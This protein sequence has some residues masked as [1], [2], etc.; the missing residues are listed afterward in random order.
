MGWGIGVGIGWPNASAGISYVKQ[1]I[2]TF[3]E[4]VLSYPN[5]VFEAEACLTASLTELNTIGLLDKAS[6]VITPNAYNTAILYDVVPN[7][8]LGDMDVIRATTATRVNANGLI[9]TV[10]LNIP[11]LDYSKGTCPSVLI[12]PQE[13][14][15]LNYSEEFDNPFWFKGAVGGVANPIVTPNQAVAPNGTLTADQ[16][17][18]PSIGSGQTS[19]IFV[20]FSTAT[21]ENYT[22]SFYIKGLLGTEVIWI[23][24]TTDGVNFLTK[25]C[26]LTI[27]WQRFDL[28]LLNF[29]G[30]NNIVIGVDTRDPL[31]T[32]RPA[33]T[34]FLWGGQLELNTYATSYIKTVASTVTRNFDKIGK[35]EITS[36][37]NASEGTFYIEV[38]ALNT[39]DAETRIFNL[40]DGDANN[41][42]V[43]I[44]FQTNGDIR[45]DLRS[46]VNISRRTVAGANITNFNKLAVSWGPLGIFG[47]ING[48][49]YFVPTVAGTIPAIP[50]AL[51]RI[52]FNR[53]ASGSIANS[54]LKESLVFKTALTNAECISLTTL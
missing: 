35:A 50:L 46:G 42:Y 30:G 20:P 11:R 7:T 32:A 16:V 53:F 28:T 19:I 21:T 18:F 29:V 27:G 15:I 24:Y 22:Q 6:L 1:L 10:G 3:K 8:V 40:N 47:Y 45:F 23:T 36:L 33:Q 5:S 49:S 43:S 31:Q 44:Q 48:S 52:Y 51:T 9:E 14:N 13:T 37:L 26:N 54:R 2:K 25:A 4:R 38:A 12:E 41:S 39:T 17:D 34:I